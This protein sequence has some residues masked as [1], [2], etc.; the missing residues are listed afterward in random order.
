MICF[1]V[2]GTFVMKDLINKLLI[3]FK[4]SENLEFLILEE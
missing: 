1:Y 2:I 4:S 3:P